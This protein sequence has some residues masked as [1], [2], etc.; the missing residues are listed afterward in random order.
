MHMLAR[1]SH[2]QLG[3]GLV[4]VLL[5]SAESGDDREHSGEDRVALSPARDRKSNFEKLDPKS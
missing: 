1:A 3:E 5:V 4:D 2:A